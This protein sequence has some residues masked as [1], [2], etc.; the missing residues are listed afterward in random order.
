MLYSLPVTCVS[1][2]VVCLNQGLF[3]S[4]SC[5]SAEQTHLQE[6][7]SE[8]RAEQAASQRL[9]LVARQAAAERERQQA[10]AATLHKQLEEE[11][12]SQRH[13]S[14]TL[15]LQVAQLNS[16]HVAAVRAA[17]AQQAQS[18]AAETALRSQVAEARRATEQ[19]MQ[20]AAQAQLACES[21]VQLVQASLEERLAS[22]AAEAASQLANQQQAAADALAARDAALQQQLAEAAADKEREREQAEKR[23]ANADAAATER[24]EALCAQ[25]ATRLQQLASVV[26]AG[27]EQVHLEGLEG[28]LLEPLGQPVQLA[29]ALGAAV[30]AAQGDSASCRL[31]AAVLHASLQHLVQ[32]ALHLR[33]QHGSAQMQVASLQQLATELQQQAVSDKQHWQQRLQQELRQQDVGW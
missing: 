29:P 5:C 17:A 19:A 10:A 1:V 16:E 22:A 32:T 15:N 18:A 3:P 24:W 14:S 9:L 8:A 2:S 31:A 6:E 28:A 13:Q 25:L 12:A 21:R 7:L 30:E 33:S 26:G 27:G 11:L 20:E 4:L 23:H